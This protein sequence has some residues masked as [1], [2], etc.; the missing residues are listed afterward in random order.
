MTVEDKNIGRLVAG[1]YR[2]DAMLGRGGF[3]SVYRGWDAEIGRDVAVKLLEVASSARTDQQMTE[4]RERFRR[5]AMAAGRINHPCIV[6]IFDFGI[7]GDGS[8]AYLVME[9]LDG[10][11]LAYELDNRGPLLPDRALRLFVPLLEALGRG[12]DLGIVHKDIK[13][14]NIFL[15]NPGTDGESLCLVDF[16]VARVVHEDK[17]TVTGLLVGTPQYMAP[18]YITDTI[19]T[20]A[21][22]V[23]QMGLILAE[24][25][26]GIPSI[27]LDETFVRSCNRHFTGDLDVPD[28]LYDGPF[29]AVLKRALAPNPNDR[30]P[31]A[32]TFMKEL[33]P[34][35]PR[36]IVLDSSETQLFTRG[37]RRVA[38]Y[39][40]P[41]LFPPMDPEQV[42]QELE[43]MEDGARDPSSQFESPRTAANPRPATPAPSES[44]HDIDPFGP[45][46]LSTNGLEAVSVRADA[47]SR[48][49]APSAVAPDR[50]GGAGKQASV[51]AA[52]LPGQLEEQPDDDRWEWGASRVT[53]DSSPPRTSGR[54]GGMATILV[55]VLLLG[56]VAVGGIFAYYEWGALR[57]EAP[58]D[59]L[60]ATGEPPA[61]EPPDPVEA[62]DPIEDEPP[63]KPRVLKLTSTPTEVG[64][65]V[66]NQRI[67]VTPAEIDLRSL[68]ATNVE[69][70]LEGYESK[71]VVAEAGEQ[72]VALEVVEESKPPKP[73]KEPSPK[74]TRERSAKQDAE[75]R[76]NAATAARLNTLIDEAGLENEDAK[77]AAAEAEAEAAAEKWEKVEK[78]EEQEES[79][80]PRRWDE[81][82]ESRKTSRPV[83]ILD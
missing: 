15:R 63:G 14:Q 36:T 64:V 60:E 51:P 21:L 61:D 56:T 22:D 18:E 55:A 54:D 82:Q 11:D 42:S 29:G 4:L 46:Q 17:L 13:P 81:E 26:T 16:G 78:P 52:K 32:T 50:S 31:D 19:V 69:L 12:H 62:P 53:D 48:E 71:L 79:K 34:I 35:D 57:A 39:D 6:T 75:S 37:D 3:G 59:A 45:T 8:E 58:D 25:I 68:D 73:K 33:S 27:P 20:P 65:Y 1:R 7:P 30:I 41:P 47:K 44:D 72:E 83:D 23:Y 40:E 70:R 2:L 76:G 67:A 5:E 66:G 38:T 10:H 77:Q 80:R 24:S 43:R 28:E 49:P 9:L 74:R